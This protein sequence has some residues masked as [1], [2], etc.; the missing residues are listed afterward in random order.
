MQ[1]TIGTIGPNSLWTIVLAM[2]DLDLSALQSKNKLSNKEERRD[3]EKALEKNFKKTLG[4]EMSFPTG[5]KEKAGTAR[6]HFLQ[7]RERTLR[8]RSG[9]GRLST[10]KRRGLIRQRKGLLP[11]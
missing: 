7:K 10:G 3:A 6:R 8:G 5:G 4:N 1:E 9:G 11:S 2:K